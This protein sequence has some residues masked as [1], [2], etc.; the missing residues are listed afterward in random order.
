MCGNSWRESKKASLTFE[1]VLHSV[2]TGAEKN[3]ATF[4]IMNTTPN[5]LGWGVTDQALEEALP[6][7][8]GKTIGCGPGYKIDDHYKNPMEVGEW[9]STEKPNGYALATA[10]IT[11]PVVLKKLK[12]KEWGPVSV[13]IDYYAKKKKN[14]ADMVDSFTFKTVDFVDKPAF[15]QAGFINFAG[16]PEEM[17]V[18]PLEL[19]ASF[20][21]S[22]STAHMR[23][24]APGSL[25]PEEKRKM[26]KIVDELKTQVE[27]L[28]ANHKKLQEDYDDL[29]AGLEKPEEEEPTDVKEDPKYK[30]LESKHKNL[31][32]KVK[33]MEDE[34]HAKSVEAAFTS[35]VK[36]GLMKAEDKDTLNDLDDGTL[37]LLARDA[38]IVVEKLEKSK[39][40]PKTKYTKDDRTELTAAMDDMR[41]TLGFEARVTKETP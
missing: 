1:A 4:Y 39:P 38:D 41:D 10:E 35:R 25:N 28:T 24:Q 5:R 15:P 8:L 33:T 31:E 3:L 32:A 17:I 40:S 34:R 16:L 26:Q 13:V 11:D 14:G 7:L 20:Y 30:E 9:V 21:E 12:S 37:I 36:A 29:K 6:T 27:T 19:C 23:G 22:Q 18:T 2:E